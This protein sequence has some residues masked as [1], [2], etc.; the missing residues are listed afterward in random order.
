MIEIRELYVCVSEIFLFVDMYCG[1]TVFHQALGS[2]LAF[3]HLKL[4]VQYKS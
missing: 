3:Y 4:C 2:A 1:W